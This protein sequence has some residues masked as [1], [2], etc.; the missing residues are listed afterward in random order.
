MRK[1]RS[2]AR[3][4]RGL[5][6]R[7]QWTFVDKNK[8]ILRCAQDGIVRKRDATCNDGAVSQE[9]KGQILMDLRVN[10]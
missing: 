4:G 10:Y 7:G 1:E 5:I 6:V 2:V 9:P 8:Q 3:R